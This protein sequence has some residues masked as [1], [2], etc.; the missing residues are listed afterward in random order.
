MRLTL[1]LDWVKSAWHQPSDEDCFAA[2][3]A[4]RIIAPDWAH[5]I[6]VEGVISGGM[7]RYRFDDFIEYAMTKRGRENVALAVLA[8]GCLVGVVVV[9]R[10]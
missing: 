10:L 8:A 2:I 4:D 7:V 1:P 6:G 9:G 3:C 5:G